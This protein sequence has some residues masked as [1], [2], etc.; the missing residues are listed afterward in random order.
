MAHTSV[1][2]FKWLW[3]L[4]LSKKRE[5][6]KEKEEGRWS[7]YLSFTP[8]LDNVPHLGSKFSLVREVQSHKSSLYG[9]KATPSLNNYYYE[10]LDPISLSLLL[11]A[12]KFLRQ[13]KE[14]FGAMS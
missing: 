1:Q 14:G 9:S 10:W 3:G 6:E 5:R 8:L 12:L 11:S 4:L 7:S 2:S 13:V